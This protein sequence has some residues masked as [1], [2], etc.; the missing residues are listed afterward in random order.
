MRRYWAI[1]LIGLIFFLGGCTN[2][3]GFKRAGTPVPTEQLPTMVA[4]TVEARRLTSTADELARVTPV[5]P[6]STPEATPTIELPSPPTVTPSQNQATPIPS[7]TISPRFSPSPTVTIFARTLTPT[8]TATLPDSSIQIRIPGPM[9]KVTSPLVVRGSVKPGNDGRIQIE[10][11]GEDGQLLLRKVDSYP[12][13]RGWAYL[14]EDLDF[15]INGVAETGRLQISTYD[16]YNRLIAIESV[17]L[18]LLSIGEDDPNPALDM[19]EP[20]VVDEPRPFK[21]IQGGWVWVSGKARLSSQRPLII[22]LIDATGKVVGY[23]QADVTLIDG[24]GYSSFGIEVPYEV[25]GATWVR[26][27]VKE[28]SNSH[29]EGVLRLASIEI[30]LS[31]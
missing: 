12:S 4:L 21:L 5:A 15:E 11:L 16:E 1:L 10:L 7:T 2:L 31:P 25:K 29:I 27:S 13:S 8:P 30:M 20:I 22:E 26:L 18:L 17:D 19:T 28:I 14:S 24:G 6:T 9:S 3:F 23:R